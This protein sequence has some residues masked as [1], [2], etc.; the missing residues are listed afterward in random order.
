MSSKTP[1]ASRSFRLLQILVL[2]LGDVSL[3]GVD[4]LSDKPARGPAEDVINFALIDHRG[5]MHELR[6]ADARAVVLFF[7]GNGC[8]I[9]RQSIWKLKAL[10]QRYSQRG[11]VFWMVNSNPQD[12]RAGIVQEAER[13]RSEPLPILKDDTQGVAR[14]LGVKRTCESIA[15]STK[16]WRIFYRGAI[17]DQLSEGAM[18]FQ[19]A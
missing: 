17:D 8:P 18:R 6:R 14:L 7:T 16:D 4:E 19:P 1:R 9:A 3:A 12:D 11:V 5:R 2:C 15:I 13:F 10:Q